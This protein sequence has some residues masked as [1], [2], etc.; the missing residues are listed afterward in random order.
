MWGLVLGGCLFERN[1]S[2]SQSTTSSTGGGDPSTTTDST[3]SQAAESSTST[4]GPGGSGDS[5]TTAVDE[6]GSA[7]S[8]SSTGSP[9][10]TDPQRVNSWSGPAFSWIGD[11]ALAPDDALV[12]VGQNAEYRALVSV[13]DVSGRP[14]WEH[15]HASG[16]S[17]AYS[18]VAVGASGVHL[19]GWEDASES[20]TF[21]LVASLGLE[22]N[23]RWAETF[24]GAADGWNSANALSLDATEQLWVVGAQT[25]PARVQPDTWLATFDAGGVAVQ[26]EILAALGWDWGLATEVWAESTVIIAGEEFPSADDAVATVRALQGT[27]E[28]WRST[29]SSSNASY[30]AKALT[31]TPED[32]LLVLLEV[33]DAE[34]VF[35]SSSVRAL[36]AAGVEQWTRGFDHPVRSIMTMEDGRWL[37]V[38][39]LEQDGWV[40]LH[41]SSGQEIWSDTIEPAEAGVFSGAAVVGEGGRFWVVG[42]VFVRGSVAP[43]EVVEYAVP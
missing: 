31:R 41:D 43:C 12:L 24:A 13:H 20:L 21:A 34:G 39:S 2:F 7:E 9:P 6:G 19:V 30:T 35:Q 23:A 16:I 17:S 33:A 1:P 5:G 22:G 28:L 27:D 29:S 32:D 8:S 18:G 26:D 42:Y 36:S 38:G 4:T 15:T 3:S 10:P 11:A 25:R 40:G 37:A 14:R